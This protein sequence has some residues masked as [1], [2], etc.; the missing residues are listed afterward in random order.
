MNLAKISLI[1]SLVLLYSVSSF[2]QLSVRVTT[3]TYGDTFDECATIKLRANV[4]NNTGVNIRR[5]YFYNGPTTIIGNAKEAPFEI[6]WENATKGWYDITARARLDDRSEAI[7]NPV[8]IN[9]G[10]TEEGDLIRNGEFNCKKT[11]WTLSL[12]GEARA[13]YSLDQ[14]LVLSGE[15]S[16]AISITNPSTANWHVTL[17]QK[18]PL[19]E[20]HT[21]VIYFLAYVDE[22]KPISF[23]FQENG[24]DWTVHHQEDI[25]VTAEE[26]E[27]GPFEWFCPETDESTEFKFLLSSN[28]VP[29]WLDDVVIIDQDWEKPST[30]HSKYSSSVSRFELPANYPNPFNLQTIIRFNLYQSE[31]IN[32]DI[33]NLRGEWVTTLINTVYPSGK[34]SVVWD[35]LNHMGREMNSGVYFYRLSTGDRI[36]TRKMIL[37]R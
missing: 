21:Y 34:H 12:S 7:S 16:G 33:L 28:T 35:G 9:I 29:I 15:S 31:K 3:P 32:L 23:N 18:F 10:N 2:A 19:Y 20:G 22:P 1:A 13:T 24:D 14:D 26:I 36:E 5:V 11:P 8:L 17:F 4:T 37:V 25:T 27:Y 6:E 30:V